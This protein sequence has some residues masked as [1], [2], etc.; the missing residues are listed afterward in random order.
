MRIL[1][2][3]TPDFA[4]PVLDA[5]VAAGHNVVRV[6]TQP[7]RPKGRGKKLTS[8]PVAI[9]AR[10]LGI[11]VGQPKSV[12]VGS[13]QKRTRELAPDVAVVVAYGRILPQEVL[14]IPTHGFVNVHASLLPRWRGS[15]PIQWAIASGDR[16]TGVSTQKVEVGLDTG[17]IYGEI[18][19][20]IGDRDTAADLHDRLSRLGAALA[21]KT[22]ENLT[23]PTPQDASCATHAPMLSRADSE[24]DWSRS[25]TVLDQRL[26][27][28]TPWPGGFVIRAN[29]EKLK[30]ITTLP[31]ELSGGQGKILATNPLTVGCQ[32]GALVLTQVQAAGKRPV[33]GSDFANGAHLRVGDLL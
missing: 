17:P 1:F 11:E 27:G 10:E 19:T 6:V 4:V 26:R 5:L 8:P 32:N 24:I 28:F 12:R 9:R 14:D 18:Q 21:V 30:I 22:L 25:A 31:V 2:M 15:A 29:G 3:G 7:D 16:V 20:E 13:F 33:S 23:N